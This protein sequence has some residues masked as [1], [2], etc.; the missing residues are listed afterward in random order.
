MKANREMFFFMKPVINKAFFH[1]ID[2][3]PLPSKSLSHVL[4]FFQ[5]LNKNSFRFIERK[6]KKIVKCKK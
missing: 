5:T 1:I 6:C 4:Q 3:K 2:P